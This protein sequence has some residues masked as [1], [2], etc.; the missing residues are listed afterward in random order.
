MSY[1]INA[2][3]AYLISKSTH[4]TLPR[5]L[6]HQKVTGDIVAHYYYV[7]LLCALKNNLMQLYTIYIHTYIL[8]MFV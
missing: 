7:F 4:T 2:I 3:G 6:D 1:N 5:G 8:N